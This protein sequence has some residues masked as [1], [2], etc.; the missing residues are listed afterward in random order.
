VAESFEDGIVLAVNHGG[1]SDSTGDIA[2]N[3]LG[4]LLG[5]GA[6]PDRWLD[7]LEMRDE[8]TRLADD[9]HTVH[10]HRDDRAF[11]DIQ[12]RYPGW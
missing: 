5:A 4:A 8:I 2:G 12:A 7:P 6:I 1:D 10:H 11:A 9:L 3:I